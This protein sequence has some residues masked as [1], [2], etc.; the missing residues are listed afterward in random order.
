MMH[1]WSLSV[2]VISSWTGD[3]G[4]TTGNG[5]T[6]SRII[7][8][9]TNCLHIS[10]SHVSCICVLISSELGRAISLLMANNSDVGNVQL[11]LLKE[12]VFLFNSN[13]NKL[14]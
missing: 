7:A 2:T 5:S 14:H 13:S 1:S 9:V 12:C 6:N 4:A 11:D 8:I 3:H 10:N